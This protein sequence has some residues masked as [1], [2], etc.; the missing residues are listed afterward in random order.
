MFILD[1]DA[2][3][4]AIGAVLSQNQDGVE[5]VISYGSRTLTK[6]ERNYCVTWKELLALVY[7]LRHFRPYLLGHQFLVRTDHAAFEMD[8][9]I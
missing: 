3:E 7:F 1:T 8:S 4:S 2:S 5:R 9:A 6:S